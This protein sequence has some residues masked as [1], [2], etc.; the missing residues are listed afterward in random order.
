MKKISGFL[1]LSM[2][3]VQ[4]MIAQKTTDWNK[5]MEPAFNEWVFSFGFNIVNNS[6]AQFKDLTNDDH[7]AFDRIPFYGSLE[8]N[9][10]NRWKVKGVM[11]LN[12]FTGGKIIDGQTIKSK[13]AGGNGA[14]YGSMDLLASYYFL[15]NEHY[16]PYLSA[17]MG[18]SHFGD[19]STQENPLLYV[20]PNEM[21]TFNLGFGIRIWFSEHWGLNLDA[22]GKWGMG[23]GNTNHH[24][25]H[26]GVLYKIK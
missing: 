8:T 21:V 10:A 13:S 5:R 17:G 11:S 3:A 7:Y 18:L 20:T 24:Q 14:S 19:Y 23:A 22:L 6:G 1:L 16:E 26:L 9:I 25:S 15:G 2:L 12:Y 4:G